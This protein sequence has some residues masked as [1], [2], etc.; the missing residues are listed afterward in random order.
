MYSLTRMETARITMVTREKDVS[1]GVRMRSIDWRA[2][3]KPTT[4]I[5]SLITRPVR[6]SMRPCPKGC[7]ASGFCPASRKPI[8]ER[9]ELPASERLFT[10][11]ATMAME[12]ERRPTASLKANRNMFKT[13][14]SAP[15]RTPQRVRTEGSFVF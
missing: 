9:M 12:E 4:R 11:S 7:S 6:Y 8:I 10:A 1:S 14:P 2:S 15:A 13:I 3:S 5:T